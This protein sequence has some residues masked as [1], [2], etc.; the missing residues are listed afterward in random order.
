MSCT[1]AIREMM[2]GIDDFAYFQTSG[3]S[4][5]PAPVIEE[6][7]RYLRLQA[8]GP[9][10]PEISKTMSDAFENARARVA[11]AMGADPDEI[12]MTENTTVG[13]NIV[14]NGIDWRAGDNVV[15]SNHEHP[16][17]RIPWYNVAERY[18]V[19]L[20]FLNMDLSDE[21]MAAH[22]E[23]LV[24]PRTR[25]VA[26]SHVSRRTGLRIRA[27]AMADVAHRQGVPLLLDG[28]QAFGAIPVDVHALGCDF[29][30][31]SGHKYIMAPQG[32]GGLYVRRDRIP[33]IRPS[34]IGS[35]SQKSLDNTGGMELRDEACRFEFGTRNLADHIG[36]GKAV[37]LLTEIGFAEVFAHIKKYTDGLKQ[38]LGDLPGLVVRTPMAYD[39]SSGIV[40]FRIPGT[41]TRELSRLLLEEQRILVCT[42]DGETDC[43]RV[44]THIFNTDE[45]ADRLVSALSERRN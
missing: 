42:L 27:T 11:V 20:R 16:G 40:T 33:W 45:E 14:A 37:E 23:R 10:L 3:L 19:E 25:V 38:R 1:K 15:I 34:W 12:V 28:A 30:T 9:A 36:F 6:T 29:Y 31:F 7:V 8:A 22:L 2:P 5:K 43:V 13:I 32:T 26:I 44:S 39:R 24:G 18:G 21:E 17:N 41:D 4:P 35:H